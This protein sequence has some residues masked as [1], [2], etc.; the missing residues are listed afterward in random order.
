M[1]G[2]IAAIIGAAWPDLD[3]FFFYLVDN[4]AFHH[5]RYWVHAPAFV[6]VVS[7]VLLALSRWRWPAACP[8]VV[9]FCCGWVLHI[10]LDSIAGGI[11][12]LWPVSTELYV[13][14]TVPPTQ[15]HWVLSFL[16]HW[17]FVAELV[18]WAAALIL[19]TRNRR[20]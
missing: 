14:F 17:T 20:A 15:S 8:L 7:L 6:L 13:L 1:P 18:I 12:W 5:H 19:L 9:A 3:L 10:L 2:M 11:M 16:L 4:R